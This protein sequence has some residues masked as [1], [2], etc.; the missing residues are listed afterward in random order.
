MNPSRRSFLLAAGGGLALVMEGGVWRAVAAPG[1]TAPW[2]EAAGDAPADVRL[3]AFRHAVLA[4]NPHNRQPWLIRLVGKNEAIITC[5]LD[6]R[7]PETDPFDRQIVIGF[8]CFLGL[9]TLAAGR[10]GHRV[11]ITPFPEG[12]G[13]PR[14]DGRPIAHLRFEAAVGLAAD[15]LAAFMLQ[16]R[17]NKQPYDMARRPEESMLAGLGAA[18]ASPLAIGGA[19]SVPTVDAIRAIAWDAWQIEARTPRTHLESVNLMRIGGAEIATQPDGIALGGP[20]IERLVA[21]GQISRAAIADPASP[22]FQAGMDLYR[23]IFEATPAFVWIAGGSEGRA[24]QLEAGRA[25]VRLNLAATRAGLSLHPVS[26]ALQEFPEMAEARAAMHRTIGVA[27]LHM[28]MRLGYGQ[29]ARETPR[30]PLA[31]RLVT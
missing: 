7:L 4:P 14:L 5:D 29:P 2:A 22:A 23:G 6:R 1:P 25:Y 30:W 17:S 18:V 27:R 28:L 3:D 13:A 16:R 26:Q 12:A 10:R 21:Q 19:F 11:T 24:D 20:M 15:P 31:T 8:G 9:A